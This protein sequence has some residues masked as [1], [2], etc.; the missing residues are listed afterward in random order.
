VSGKGY[1]LETPSGSYIEAI[2]YLLQMSAQHTADPDRP[3]F[4]DP[5]LVRP[6]LG[7]TAFKSLVLT[8]YHRR[9]AITGAKILPVLEAAHIRPVTEN[10]EHR[11]DNGL[12]LRSDV[13]T[14]FDAGYLSLDSGYRLRVS[15]R[16]RRE[17]S[18]GEEFYARANEQISIPDR[19]GERPAR[20]AIEWHMDT[21]FLPS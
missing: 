4:G 6:R 15:P 10:G 9:C 13:H 21:K 7:Q 8:A 1:D 12:L 18:N 19:P 14:L 17:F 20:E 16:L 11:L 5:R 2:R 3:M